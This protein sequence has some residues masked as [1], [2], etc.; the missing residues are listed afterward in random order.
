MLQKEVGEDV[1]HGEDIYKIVG[2][3]RNETVGK[4][5]EEVGPNLKEQQTHLQ[6]LERFLDEQ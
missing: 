2:R 3:I 4:F 6:K 5:K 1:P